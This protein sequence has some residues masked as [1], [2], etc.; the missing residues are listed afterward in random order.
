MSAFNLEIR[1]QLA[2]Y[3]AGHVSLN[4]FRDWFAPQAWNIDQRVDTATA[5]M[6]HEI[7]L[8]LAEFD[9]GDWTEEEVKRLFTSLITE[10]TLIYLHEAPWLQISTSSTLG[11]QLVDSTKYFSVP[12]LF[13]SP[14]I[15]PSRL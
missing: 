13:Q 3:I 10:S 14:Q 2:R 1:D 11:T 8:V 5:R 12:P 9:H 15:Q 4:A 6:V 7:D